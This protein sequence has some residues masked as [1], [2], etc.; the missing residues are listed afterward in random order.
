MGFVAMA[1]GNHE[2]DWGEEYVEANAELAEFPFIAINI[3]DRDTNQLVDYCQ[4]S[5]V[6]EAGDIQIGIIGAMGN[7]YSSIASEKSQ[8]WK[9]LYSRL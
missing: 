9:N 4:P 7:C 6:V 8:V 1:L 2:Y 3:Y 5:V